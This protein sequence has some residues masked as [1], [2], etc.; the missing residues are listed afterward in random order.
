MPGASHAGAVAHISPFGR[1][2]GYNVGSS[3]AQQSAASRLAGSF[4]AYVT[5]LFS[6]RR[7]C[8]RRPECLSQ[9]RHGRSG[10]WPAHSVQPLPS[11]RL[12]KPHHLPALRALPQTL[13]SLPDVGRCGRALTA[14]PLAQ[15]CRWM[16]DYG[17]RWLCCG[18]V[19]AAAR[20][21]DTLPKA[22]SNI[23][24]D[25]Y[26]D[27]HR[28]A[29]HR[30]P[31]AAHS[32]ANNRGASHRGNCNRLARHLYKDADADRDGRPCPLCRTSRRHIHRHRQSLRAI[33]G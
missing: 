17:P 21:P 5:T 28:R 11:P 15:F 2:F 16:G 25:L 1:V 12:F 20:H 6:L 22:R 26:P 9:L 27:G 32:A 23:G 19:S 29:A 31:A 30:H 13:A 7:R 33:S 4:P 24:A 3:L 14:P 18:H 8:A 10:P